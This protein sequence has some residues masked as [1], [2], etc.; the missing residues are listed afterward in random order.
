M[1]NIYAIAKRIEDNKQQLSEVNLNGWKL[2]ATPKK[3]LKL[4]MNLWKNKNINTVCC[5]P[6]C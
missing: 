1:E 4:P 5:A 6:C 2:E 3:K